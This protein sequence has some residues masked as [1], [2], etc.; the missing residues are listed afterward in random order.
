MKK[1][2]VCCFVVVYQLWATN[3]YVNQ[4]SGS[5]TNNGSESNPWKTL[6]QAIA[7][8][9]ENKILCR[10]PQPVGIWFTVQL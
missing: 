3:Y 7:V 9:N 2:L 1:I 5:D 8:I 4:V 10:R 6:K